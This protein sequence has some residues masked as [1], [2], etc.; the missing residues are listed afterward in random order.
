MSIN[1]LSFMWV[2]INGITCWTALLLWLQV[3]WKE[4]NALYKYSYNEKKSTKSILVMYKT[5]QLLI[6]VYIT[7]LKR[8]R[9]LS[10]LL[11]SQPV[12]IPII[13]E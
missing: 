7:A 1:A 9:I 12:G 4:K 11:H 3:V 5:H 8:F 6:K 13:N 10:N 2:A